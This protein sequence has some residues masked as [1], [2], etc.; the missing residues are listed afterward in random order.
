IAIQTSERNGAVV[1]AVLVNDTD[2]IMLI[3]DG[4]ILVRTRVREISV[5][6]R[7]TQGV[8]VIRLDKGERVVGVDRIDGLGDE[9]DA[10]GELDEN[11]VEIDSADAGGEEE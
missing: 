2:E 1:G 4:G 8:T 9:D 5:V 6:G 11:D 3:T 10:E 7:N